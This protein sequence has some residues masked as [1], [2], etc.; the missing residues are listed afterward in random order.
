MEVTQS[1]RLIDT[2]DTVEITLNHVEGQNMVSWENIENVFPGVHR[3]RNGSSVIKFHRSSIQQSNNCCSHSV[4]EVALSTST[5]SV[6]VEPPKLDP[7]DRHFDLTGALADAAIEDSNVAALDVAPRTPETAVA[8]A[9]T[10]PSPLYGVGASSKV[11][12]FQ[13]VATRASRKARESEIEQRFISLLAPEVQETV[14]ASPDIYQAFTQAIKNGNGGLSR[15][16]LKQELS[17]PFQ[18]LEAIMVAMNTELQEELSSMRKEM[19]TKQDELRTKQEDMIKLQEASDAKQEEIIRLQE[20]MKQLQIQALGQLAVLHTRV[21]AV[22][23]QTYELHEYPIPRLFV[24]LPQDSS[25]WNAVDP[26]SNKFRLYFLCECGEHTKSVD[27]NTHIHFAKHEGYG[28]ARPTEFFRLYGSHVFT[29]LKM[30]KFGIS[31]AGVVVPAIS[32]L[33]RS[34]AVK[35]AATYLKLLKEL[36]PKMEPVI[37]WMDKV[38]A[39][40]GEA[41]DEFTKQMKSKEALAGADLRKLDTFLKAKDGDK[42]LGNLYRTVTDEGHVKWV[43]IDHYRENYQEITA[44]DFQR[45]LAA[46]GGSFDQSLGRVEVALRSREL[47]QQFFSVLGKAR[48]LYELDIVF[49]W[50]CTT[51]DLELLEGALKISTRVAVLKLDIRQFRRSNLSST[52]AQY[53]ALFRI[54][55]HPKMRIIRVV[56]SSNVVKLLSIQPKTSSCHCKLS[57]E[58]TP[59]SVTEK[60]ITALAEVLKTN[61]TLTTLDLQ[62]N[63]VGDIGAQALSEAL[64]TN[65]TLTTLALNNNNIG[66]NGAQA[67]AYA[68]KTNKTLTTLSLEGNFIRFNGGLALSKSLKINLTLTTLYLDWESIT[69][70]R[71]EELTVALKTKSTLTTLEMGDKSIGDDG[72]KALAE[73]LKTNS[74]VATLNL[75]GNS[76]GHDGAKALA[77]ALKTNSTL[78]TLD[79][80]SNKIGKDGAKALAEALKTNSTLNTLDLMDNSIKDDGAKAVG[81]ALKINK[82]LTTLSLI[83][84]SIKNDGAKAVAEALKTNM[85]LTT[86]SLSNN[87]VGP[88]GAQALAEAL[89]TNKVLTTLHLNWNNIG[90]NEAQALAETLKTNKTLTTLILDGNSIGPM[91]LKS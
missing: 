31:V 67:L 34:D 23:T 40:E 56:L 6:D 26:F 89:K 3:V 15:A 69:F 71:V 17:G 41:I 81:E 35:E 91:E 66:D 74:N 13:Q 58:V 90:P 36:E 7:T 20:E 30:L 63:S 37:D 9:D 86:L 5:K 12:L 48:S 87:P 28:I 52:S 53:G 38:A 75:E 61:T 88:N 4:L 22:L 46:V 82:T 59:Q 24:V 76:I 79:L 19:N 18:R 83:K 84:N 10:S 25:G 60:E 27:S 45:T 39:D 44:K 55:G 21:Q 29:I 51:S 57:I 70:I 54:R 73:A 50:A 78:T 1:L 2:L 42:V 33:V 85:T 65:S 11:A 43:C 64:Q 16:D 49:D 62:S 68:L 80:T 47:A 72:A 8:S 14:R 77:E 32:E